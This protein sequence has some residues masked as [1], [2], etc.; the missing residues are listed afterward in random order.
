MQ[1][2]PTQSGALGFLPPDYLP[3]ATLG[4]SGAD[5]FA[6]MLKATATSLVSTPALAQQ[7]QA[8]ASTQTSTQQASPA[9][10]APAA[11][12]PSSTPPP[13]VVVSAQAA[14]L[15]EPAMPR[16]T[17]DTSLRNVKMTKQDYAG[18]EDKLEKAGIPKDKL[19]ELAQKIQSS[20]GL[21]WGQFMTSLHKIVLDQVMQP[22]QLT[23]TD[24]S[25]ISSLLANL[26]FDPKKAD[27]LTNAL[28][29]G[30]AAPVFAQISAQLKQMDPSQTATVTADQLASLSKALKLSDGATQTLLGQFG[31]Q[32][33]LELSP[34]G[35]SQMF[36]AVQDDLSAQLAQAND[37]MKAIK[38]L[39]D[40][41]MA[42]AKQNLNITQ[43]AVD[44]QVQSTAVKTSTLLKAPQENTAR[45]TDAGNDP[46][47]NTAGQAQDNA[48]QNN[49]PQDKDAG[50]NPWADKGPGG[51][52]NP[53]DP[54]GVLK[55]GGQSGS[56]S[57]GKDAAQD[58]KAS[59]DRAWAQFASKLQTQGDVRLSAESTLGVEQALSG[60]M[61]APVSAQALGL[62]TGLAQGLANT[63]GGQTA[64]IQAAQFL[65][66]V[67]SG[68]L[69]N[70][71]Q[72]VK[73]LTLE[74]TPETLGKL[75]V[76]L[77]V[78]GKEVQ[79]VIKA[80]TPE[81][82]KVLSDNLQQIKQT[83]ENQGLT[84]SKLEVRTGVPQDA[85][86]GQQ[87]A[88]AD[89]HNL[90][91]ERRDALGRMHTSSMLAGDPDTMAQQMQSGGVE[92]K[93][94]QGG[95]DIMA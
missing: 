35:L 42:K 24:K 67:Q 44:N 14:A 40:P 53:G 83:L 41:S 85:N 46:G 59:S 17:S 50:N 36:S 56:Q 75:N 20:G 71:G 6:N 26:G 27:E 11:S 49:A 72:G 13:P 29:N 37:A 63:A 55:D 32:G 10:P 2:I 57:Q 95:L 43:Q 88:G 31:S 16:N 5:M 76:M 91:Q 1:I 45:N 62:G 70:M 9:Q 19:D 58:D 30:K 7:A 84:V 92:V 23:D 4:V 82:E 61:S 12:Q 81:A 18:L 15:Q 87:W 28:A 34:A 51:H 21:T 48:P 47:T 39:V 79:A 60:Q 89:K 86:L 69:T 52:P 64:K 8:P 66:Q 65:D 80:D 3:M 93:N 54:Q 38:S 68:I 94:S 78:K 25:N 73:Q 77:T 33:S 22:T 74:L 90:S